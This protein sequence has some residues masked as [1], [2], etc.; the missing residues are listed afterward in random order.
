MSVLR[1]ARRTRI[2]AA[3]WLWIGWLAIPAGAEPT[4]LPADTPDSAASDPAPAADATQKMVIP[5][6]GQNAG[7]RTGIDALLKLP[8]GYGSSS[9]AQSVAGAD[10]SEWRRRFRES[11]SAIEKARG[12][13][14]KAKAELDGAAENSGGTQWNVAPPGGGGSPTQG[15][16]PLSFKL[17]QELKTQR[18]DLDEAERRFRELEIEANLAGVPKAW[19]GAPPASDETPPEVGQL[20]D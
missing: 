9:T 10:E 7:P 19:R 2:L 1:S 16:S 20:L 3:A 4:A 17:R 11:L 18:R 5:S 15:T 14:A 12:G 6:D 13:L 8:S